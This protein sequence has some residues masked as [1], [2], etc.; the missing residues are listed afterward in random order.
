MAKEYEID[1]GK[2]ADKIEQM[3]DKIAKSGDRA[4]KVAE[5]TGN[6]IGGALMKGIE[7]ELNDFPSRIASS[8][9]KLEKGFK[10]LASKI[11]SQKEHLMTSIG[12]KDIVID[13]DFSNVNVDSK[14]FKDKVNNAFKNF[15]ADNPIE[16]DTKASETQLKNILK[17]YMKYGEKL[18]QLQNQAPKLKGSDSLIKNMQ[19]QMALNDAINKIRDMLNKSASISIDLPLIYK[20]SNREL[21]KNIALLQQ[22]EKSKKH[23]VKKNSSSIAQLKEENKELIERNKILEEQVALV[24]D[25]SK[26]TAN[27]HSG[28][29]PKEPIATPKTHE[30]EPEQMSMLPKVKTPNKPAKNKPR[31]PKQQTV[32]EEQFEQIGM[33]IDG[34]EPKI[35]AD[36]EVK[37]NDIKKAVE[38]AAKKGNKPKI[39]AEAVFDEDGDGGKNIWTTPRS[40]ERLDTLNMPIEYKGENGQDA[41]QMFA[42]LKS[43]IEAMTGKPVTIDF[44]SNVN[45]DGQLE[46]IG[47]SL[48]YVNEEAGVTVKQFYDIS[49]NEEGV[50]VA[51]QSYEK[52][53][54]SATKA[55]K[56]FNAEMQRKVANAQIKT[57]E[58]QM[59]SLPLDLDKVKQAAADIN[60]K[61]SLDKFNLELKAAKE[62]AK[63]LK[64]ELKGQNALDTIASMERSALALPSD[65]ERTKRKLDELGDVD[66]VQAVKD[67]LQS[68]EEEYQKF[69][70]SDKSEEKTKAF[71]SLSTSM[72]WIKAEMKNLTDQ[73]SRLKREETE[74][75]QEELAKQKTA[76]SSYI[77]WWKDSLN[78]Q[79][80]EEAATAARNKQ[81]QAYSNWWNKALHDR[82]Q[83]EKAKDERVIEARKKKEAAYDAWWQKQFKLQEIAEQKKAD[84]PHLDY[85]K[86]TANAAN[87]KLDQIQGQYDALGVTNPQVK[88]QMKLYQAKVQEIINLRK[89]FANDPNAAKDPDMVRQFQRIVYEADNARK[90][91]K[92]ILDDEDKMAQL[93]SEQ[94]FL[95][96]PVNEL[97]SAQAQLE[98][99]AREGAEGRVQIKGW[100]DDNTK[101]TYTITNAKGSVQEMTVAIG[102]GTNTMY[103]YR[104]ATKEMGTTWEQFMTGIRRKAKEISTFILGGGSIYKVISTFRQGIQYIREIDAALTELKK[105]TDETEETYEKFLDTASKTAAKVGS[106][107]KD[108]VN[109]TADWARL[110]IWAPYMVTY[111]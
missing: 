17:L 81:E 88:K 31:K 10:Q 24:K 13:V 48:K 85:G 107:I 74:V 82:E 110:N 32:V 106:T 62:E 18:S 86:T 80:K 105:V 109:S 98:S 44:A 77:N 59:G 52:A 12:G 99:F 92:A 14:D 96:M 75:E 73:N 78:E 42:G 5:Q 104:T 2:L 108:V 102:Q 53:T 111:R 93:S 90:S 66:G 101:L 47:A 71:R 16:F 1:F 4:E 84:K 60:D 41:V 25:K 51:T 70:T 55:A 38:N 36:V 79:A 26:T 58:A 27:K 91:I 39:K 67:V 69:L 9:I 30:T 94:G 37:P 61:S 87:R 28:S 34:A 8:S 64:A 33:N 72:T 54:I 56:N 7:D 57:L 35:Q 20:E 15:K 6:E 49:R 21:S 65:L 103:K 95:T 22:A 68:V 3:A 19:E 43:Q 97:S 11:K 83:Q 76:R 46:A 45:E 63:Q 100:N 89:Q 50:L 23:T 29:K 40:G